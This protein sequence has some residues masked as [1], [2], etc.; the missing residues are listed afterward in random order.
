ML[1]RN[2]NKIIEHFGPWRSI[3]LLLGLCSATLLCTGIFALL[4]PISLNFDS[5]TITVSDIAD[6]NKLSE[7]LQANSEPSNKLSMHFRPGLFKAAAGLRDKPLADKTI[8]RIKSQLTLMCVMKMNNRPVAYI[9]IKSIGLKKC[10][11]GDSVSDLFT[12]LNINEQNKSVEI[13]IVDHKTTLQ[14]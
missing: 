10:G 1:K 2:L 6:D 5:Q 9:N 14:L 3:H 7:A 8:D 4:F 13:S 11:I 12:V